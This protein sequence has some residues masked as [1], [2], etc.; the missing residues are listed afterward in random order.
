VGGALPKKWSAMTALANLYVHPG[1]AVRHNLGAHVS[2][3]GPS[4]AC[5]G[6]D[7]QAHAFGARCMIPSNSRQHGSLCT[8]SVSVSMHYNCSLCA[9]SVC[10]DM[11]S[12]GRQQVLQL[13][14]QRMLTH[15]LHAGVGLTNCTLLSA[16]LLN[17]WMGRHERFRGAV[18]GAC[19]HVSSKV[20]GSAQQQQ[21]AQGHNQGSGALGGRGLAVGS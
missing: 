1:H 8:P 13:F 18:Q 20:V 21:H 2:D 9:P 16:S 7:M 14:Q 10:A 17:V 4:V 19:L 6:T 5:E 15:R 12:M 11:P 3:V